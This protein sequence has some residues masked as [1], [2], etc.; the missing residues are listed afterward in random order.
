MGF[1][2]PAAIGAKIG[3][4]DK[5]VVCFSGDGG[6]QMNIQEM[7]TAVVQE[8]PVIICVFNNYYLGMVRQMQQLFTASATRPPACA[9][10]RDARR[11]ARDRMHPARRTRRILSHLQKATGHTESVWSARRIIRRR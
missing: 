9:E 7:A 5:E 4:P 2:L 8:A 1:G 11:T 3:N 10:E 6:L